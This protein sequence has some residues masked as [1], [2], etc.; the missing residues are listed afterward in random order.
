LQLTIIKEEPWKLGQEITHTK[1]AK[2][3]LQEHDHQQSNP[4]VV[5]EERENYDSRWDTRGHLE[6]GCNRWTSQSDI[7][8]FFV[9][10][11]DTEFYNS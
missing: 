1:I 7:Q 10:L 4:S 2:E 11:L 8:E 5:K 6:N 9:L 3:E